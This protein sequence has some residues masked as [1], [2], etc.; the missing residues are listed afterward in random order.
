MAKKKYNISTR[1]ERC[2]GCNI[3]VHFCPKH[4][5]KLE[6]GKV[7]VIN[8]EECIGCKLCE[9]RCPDYAI[10]VEEEGE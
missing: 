5:L 9:L 2:K 3:C 4:V 7:K 10:F 1:E 6:K 8:P